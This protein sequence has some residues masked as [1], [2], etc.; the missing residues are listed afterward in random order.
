MLATLGNLET[1]Y[2]RKHLQL[3]LFFG[4]PAPFENPLQLSP[5]H[6]VVPS[7]AVQL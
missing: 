2:V 5:E 3:A 4:S 7:R 1:S 6:P